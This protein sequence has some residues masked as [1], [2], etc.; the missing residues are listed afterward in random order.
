[1]RSNHLRFTQLVVGTQTATNV[2][3]AWVDGTT[4]P[5]LVEKRCSA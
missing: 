2:S 1:M 5:E 3:V 4:D